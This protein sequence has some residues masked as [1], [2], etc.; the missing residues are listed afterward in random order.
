M[1]SKTGTPVHLLVQ[2]SLISVKRL[3]LDS[4]QNKWSLKPPL[5][6]KRP[7]LN[8]KPISIVLMLEF[9]FNLVVSTFNVDTIP[10]GGAHSPVKK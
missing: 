1:V 8:A 4:D 2:H 9:S 3:S 6:S 5:F 7:G 10:P